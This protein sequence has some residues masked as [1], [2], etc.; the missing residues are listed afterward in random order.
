ML[1]CRSPADS[2]CNREIIWNNLYQ[3]RK[4]VDYEGKRI[5]GWGFDL[6]QTEDV[7]CL[8]WQNGYKKCAICSMK[9]MNKQSISAKSCSI[10]ECENR[11][12]RARGCYY[13]QEYY[14]NNHRVLKENGSRNN[15]YSDYHCEKCLVLM[16]M[17]IMKKAVKLGLFLN[18]I[19]DDGIIECIA[20]FA[21][22]FIVECGYKNAESGVR[23]D[24]MIV[25]D[26]KFQCKSRK[27][28]EGRVIDFV[29]YGRGANDRFYDYSGHPR[30]HECAFST[31]LC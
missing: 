25:W 29:E 30:C 26:N 27:D 8:Y 11:V 18:G 24:N 10:K 23:C 1:Q 19:K 4:N 14:C 20:G 2:E 6:Y 16:E 7:N 15:F 17:N 28:F 13:C 3:W 12:G 21:V 31:V 22:G 5:V 9:S